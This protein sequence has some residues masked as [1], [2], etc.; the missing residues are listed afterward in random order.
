MTE[1]A[2]P[3]SRSSLPEYAH[4]PLVAATLGVF[5]QTP[6]DVTRSSLA[7]FQQSLG[8]EWVGDWREVSLKPSAAARDFGLLAMGEELNNVLGDRVLRISPVHFSFTWLGTADARYPRYENLRDGFLSAWDCWVEQ[9]R[10][11]VGQF[12]K[13]A[14]L[15]LNQIPQ[16]TVWQMRATCRSSSCSRVRRNGRNG[17]DAGIGCCVR[18]AFRTASPSIGRS[19]QDRK[20]RTRTASGCG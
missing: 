6:L 4:P 3:P 20:R 17:C 1:A 15:Y 14:V 19:I 11:S 8:P 18:A 13:W 2:L 10:V 9:Q 7:K 16:G 5:F 12:S